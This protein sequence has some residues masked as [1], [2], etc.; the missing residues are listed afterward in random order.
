MLTKE[1]Y[2]MAQILD[3]GMVCCTLL[4]IGALIK[5]FFIV[6]ETYFHRPPSDKIQ[7]DICQIEILSNIS[8]PR[9]SPF[10]ILLPAAFN[11]RS[12]SAFNCFSLLR[13][14]GLSDRW[15]TPSGLTGG[16]KWNVFGLPGG[17][18]L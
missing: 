16:D 13:P 4:M 7:G 1:Y 5:C 2:Y 12:F 6:R 17:G 11:R 15:Y 14:L 8:L 18:G 10:T 9:F 3:S